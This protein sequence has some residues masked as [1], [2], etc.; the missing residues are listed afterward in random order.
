MSRRERHQRERLHPLVIFLLFGTGFTRTAAFMSLPFLVFYLTHFIHLTPMQ[1]G[2]VM[3]MM[4][5]GAALGGFFGG[6]LSDLFGRGSI[7]VIS[8][9]AWTFCF[10]G[11]VIAQDYEFFLIL[12]LA[13]GLCRAFFEPTSQALMADLTIPNRR[14]KVFG[15][16]YTT[17]NIGMVIGPL[18]GTYFFQTIGAYTFVITG[19]LFILFSFMLIVFLAKYKKDINNT[20]PEATVQLSECVHVMRKDHTL[21]YYIL[22]GMIF[23]GVYSQLETSLPMFLTNEIT[24]GE[25]TYSLL[26]IINA[27][28]VILFQPLI[29]NWAEKK[30]SLSNIVLGCL[31]FSVGYATF[32]L[33]NQ[34]LIFISG[35]ILFTLGEILIFPVT[36]QLVDQLAKDQYRGAYYGAANFAQIGLSWGPLA[37][38]WLY[39]QIGA[40]M[41]WV[42]ISLIALHIVWFYAYG[43]QLYMRKQGIGVMSILYQIFNDLKLIPIFKFT[44]KII[45]LISILIGL[46]FWANQQ[47]GEKISFLHHWVLFSM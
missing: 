22:G 25:K 45:P 7:L 39:N 13:H 19:L 27:L 14:L 38:S 43:F 37:G 30:N 36:N 28:M 46:L 35:T 29:T 3:A 15:Y 24:G 5:L 40:P 17:I 21:G 8:L 6:Y 34:N 44:F 47:F 4:G 42:I 26:L 20:R 2:T 33:G 11:F 18:L 12:S 1:V 41:M 32:S 10:F 31:L 9:F 23:F 16:R